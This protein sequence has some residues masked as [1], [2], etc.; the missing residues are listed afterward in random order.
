M[1]TF[2]NRNDKRIAL[3]TG[4]NKGIGYEIARQL[5]QAG[6]IVLVG[7]RDADRG[8]AAAAALEKEG[9]SARFVSLDVTDEA[10]AKA[11]ATEIGDAFGYLDVLVNNAGISDRGDGPPSKASL[12]ASRRLLETNFFGALTVTQAMLP[13][14]RRSSGA[15]IVNM[16]SSLGSLAGNDD[17]TSPYYGARLIG[18]NASKAALNMLTVQLAHELRPEGILV[19]SACPGYVA[20]D[21]NGHGG[22]LTVQE[23]ATVP[24]RLALLPEGDETS[25]H[26]VAA[27]GEVSW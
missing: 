13:L 3:V 27:S 10:S 18:Y 26:F 14:L 21:L 9:L 5:G 17:P 8:N 2:M 4:A 22:S 12:E 1:E 11:A 23:G 20:T 19:N 24:V 25:G 6:L 15:R 7:A 16:S